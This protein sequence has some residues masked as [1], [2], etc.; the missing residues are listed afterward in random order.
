VAASTSGL[1]RVIDEF[2][3]AARRLLKAILGGWIQLIRRQLR[4]KR[5]RD[6]ARGEEGWGRRGGS[7]TPC[8]AVPERT[9]RRPD[10]LIYS[11]AYLMKLG[12]AVTWDNPDITLFKDGVAVPSHE[13][14][15]GTEYQVAARIW[16]G[17]TDAPA[18][19]LP[20][21]LSYMDFGIGGVEQPIGQTQIDLPVKGAPGHPA[22]AT[23]P[24][25]TPAAPG[26][27]CLLVKL[28]W[29]DDANPYNNLGQENT[30]VRAP[31]SPAE[32]RFVVRNDARRRR[33]LRLEADAYALPERPPCPPSERPPKDR[34]E[35]R[36]WHEEDAVRRRRR[37]EREARLRELANR[38]A[39][40]RFPV[41]AG[42]T[43]GIDQPQLTLEAGEQEEAVVTVEPP[44]GFGGRQ[45]VNVNA[46]DGDDFAGGVT[47]VVER[48]P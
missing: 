13:L 11:Q 19:G 27:Y 36:R 31:S 5:R 30:D 3:R 10:P 14:Q 9:Y 40:S 22:V 28:L 6:E 44:A 48:S 45:P 20:I 26:H 29:G 16:N 23:V 43:V 18:V 37:R 42:W 1:D 34:D 41:P 24:W 47:L 35:P 21:A 25:R 39:R 7:R 2:L 15:P 46:F 33:T 17:S 38:H 32:F 4:R 8:V 12:L